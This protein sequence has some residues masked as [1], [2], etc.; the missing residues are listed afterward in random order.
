METFDDLVS[1]YID[2]INDVMETYYQDNYP[3]LPYGTKVGI[4]QGKKYIRIVRFNYDR[5]TGEMNDLSSSVYGFIV[6]GDDN[7]FELGDILKAKG[8]KSP[9]R[10]FVRG[11]IYT[12]NDDS[13]ISPWS[14]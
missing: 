5:E 8:W 14:V 12:V 1:S 9:A 4:T 6:A 11:S 3:N 2:R 13:D 7:K 10:N